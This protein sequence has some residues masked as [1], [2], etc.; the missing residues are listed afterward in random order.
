[1]ALDHL[2]QPFAALVGV[3][4]DP[5]WEVAG[6]ACGAASR[7]HVA[8]VMLGVGLLLAGGALGVRALVVV[9]FFVVVVVGL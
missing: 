1:M 9:V 8:E 3:G 4:G 6:V 7:L 2:K 5:G